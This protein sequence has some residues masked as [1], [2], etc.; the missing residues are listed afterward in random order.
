[1][2]KSMKDGKKKL[3]DTFLEQY[4]VGLW[5]KFQD[6]L[7]TYFYNLIAMYPFSIN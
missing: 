5:P 1:M 2:C 3:Q 7:G 6:F 4:E